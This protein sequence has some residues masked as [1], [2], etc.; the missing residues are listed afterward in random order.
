MRPAKLNAR[1]LKPLLTIQPQTKQYLQHIDKSFAQAAPTFIMH[2]QSQTIRH[3]H[4]SIMHLI[5]PPKFC[6]TFV[7]HFSWALQPS[8]EKL[9]IMLMQNFLPAKTSVSPRSS[10]RARN[11]PSGEER[12]DTDVFAG[13]KILGG[14]YRSNPPKG[15]FLASHAGVFRGARISSLPSSPKNACVGG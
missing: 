2:A 8:Q 14:K 5:Y 7:F 3:L 10:P 15:G 6:I 13:Y 12:G 11:V 4:T 1:R 9:K